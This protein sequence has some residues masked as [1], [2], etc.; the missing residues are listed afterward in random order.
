LVGSS[1][2]RTSGRARAD[3]PAARELADV[4]VHHVLV[5]AEAG[6]DLARAGVEAV[7]AE[8]LEAGLDLAEAGDEGVELVHARG[9]GQRLLERGQLGGDDRDRAGAVH[10]L[11]DDA[12]PGHLADVLAEVAERD[13][14][15]DPHLALVGALGLHDHAE[16][17]GLAGPV[18]PDEA[19]LLAAEHGGRGFDEQQLLAVLLRD[20]VD[21]DHGRGDYMSRGDEPLAKTVRRCTA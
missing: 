20:G 15:L 7:A 10:G 5:E 17:G 6:E 4:A 19:D 14:L 12:A 13:A 8:L 3:L 9:V 1:S 21:V 18:G 11:G 2:S 16:D